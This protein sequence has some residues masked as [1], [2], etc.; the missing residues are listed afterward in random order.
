[1]RWCS[2]DMRSTMG[3]L[4]DLRLTLERLNLQLQYVSECSEAELEGVNAQI[5]RLFENG[6][7]ERKILLGPIVFSRSNGVYG[8]RESGEVIQAALEV[9]GGFGAIH[10]DSD[11]LASV[12]NDREEHERQAY[13]SVV[14]FEDCPVA[15]RALVSQHAEELLQKLLSK[16][17]F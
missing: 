15:I 17:S 10:W 9:P 11:M 14:P 16:I 6:L 12:Q 7:L 3:T 4:K 1:M 13:G 2:I 5:R 8:C